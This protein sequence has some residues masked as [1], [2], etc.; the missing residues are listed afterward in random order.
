MT[1]LVV[2]WGLKVT[3]SSHLSVLEVIR[4]TN[5][6]V[7]NIENSALEIV[8][9]ENNCSPLSPC[10]Y[11]YYSQT[12]DINTGAGTDARRLCDPPWGG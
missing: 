1:C 4:N 12:S 8:K 9:Y 7:E 3:C 6:S 2:Y 5:A 10:P 11:W